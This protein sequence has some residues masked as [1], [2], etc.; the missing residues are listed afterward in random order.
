MEIERQTTNNFH[1]QEERGQANAQR[2]GLDEE[3]RYSS[4]DRKNAASG[5]NFHCVF[6]W[7]LSKCGL[8]LAL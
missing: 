3:A 8:I 2:D 4:V 1:L 5:M 7:F 6:T